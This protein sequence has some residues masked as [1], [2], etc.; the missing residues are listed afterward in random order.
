M[1]HFVN[2]IFFV[3]VALNFRWF[4]FKFFVLPKKRPGK[5]RENYWILFWTNQSHTSLLLL[6]LSV[7]FSIFVLCLADTIDWFVWRW[8]L[9]WNL[10]NFIFYFVIKYLSRMR[11][12]SSSSSSSQQQQHWIVS[13]CEIIFFSRLWWKFVEGSILDTTSS[14]LL[15]FE[16]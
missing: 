14:S 9:L 5:Q 7:S 1:Q 3:F 2:W 12:S 11:K 15:R 10:Q 4:F 6:C 13:L 16:P 8:H